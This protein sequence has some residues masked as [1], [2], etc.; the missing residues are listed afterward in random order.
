MSR[1]LGVVGWGETG[2][3]G[4][5][6]ESSALGQSGTSAEMET[7]WFSVSVRST[8]TTSFSF[9]FHLFGDGHLEMGPGDN[10]T[11]LALMGGEG[12]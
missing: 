7:G 11:R 5:G 1:G 12:M 4:M 6:A 10:G 8:E 9:P 3:V 2:R